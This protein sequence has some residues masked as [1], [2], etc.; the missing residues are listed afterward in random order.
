[1]KLKLADG[2]GSAVKIRSGHY[3]MSDHD[4]RIIMNGQDCT[5]LLRKS[6]PQ[7]ATMDQQL[8]LL[9]T[10]F[11]LR[12][13]GGFAERGTDGRIAAHVEFTGATVHNH[14]AMTIMGIT[15]ATFATADMFISSDPDNPTIFES[16]K[17]FAVSRG[18]RVPQFFGGLSTM[19]ADLAGDLF[20]KAAMHYTEGK[21]QGQYIAISDQKFSPPGLPPFQLELDF[22]GTFDLTL[23]LS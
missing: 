1:M 9:K 23:D 19:E 3:L 16:V 18:T 2:L 20:I 14:Q 21:I 10:S 15:E 11:E 5:A 7:F 13:S 17:D 8:E 12:V 6:L 4:Y 22:A